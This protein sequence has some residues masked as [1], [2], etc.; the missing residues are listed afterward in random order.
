MFCVYLLCGVFCSCFWGGVPYLTPF[1]LQSGPF[2]WRVQIFWPPPPAG[3]WFPPSVLPRPPQPWQV[4]SGVWV[5]QIWH[6]ISAY[7]HL[8]V[9]GGEEDR[10]QKWNGNVFFLWWNSEKHAVTSRVDEL[11]SL[12]SGERGPIFPPPLHLRSVLQQHVDLFTIGSRSMQTQNTC[13]TVYQIFNALI[14]L[15]LN[16]TV[17]CLWGTGKGNRSVRGGVFLPSMHRLLWTPSLLRLLLRTHLSTLKALGRCLLRTFQVHY[18][19]TRGERTWA[20]WFPS[21]LGFS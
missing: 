5:F 9:S 18:L 13:E 1:W 21:I 14:A 7:I 15:L 8:F 6:P 11:G 2:I 12:N 20:I 10:R 4:F 19:W 3:I 17:V 16:C